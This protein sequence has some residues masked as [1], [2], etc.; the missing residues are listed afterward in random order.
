MVWYLFWKM[1]GPAMSLT[2]SY[3]WLE[4]ASYSRDADVRLLCERWAEELPGGHN[5][6]YSF[7]FEAVPR[8][9][10]EALERMIIN[11]KRALSQ[12]QERL[13]LLLQTLES[14]ADPSV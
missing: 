10:K 6:H 11:E 9:P 8:P 7:G 4:R 1:S 12:H 2:E 5:T 14:T 13:E 3:Q